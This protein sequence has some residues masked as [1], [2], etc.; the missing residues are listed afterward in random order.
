MDANATCTPLGGGIPPAGGFPERW[1][2]SLI[3]LA[4]PPRGSEHGTTE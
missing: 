3:V 1:L 2:D 4:K